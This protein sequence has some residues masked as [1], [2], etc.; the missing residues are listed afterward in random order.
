MMAW[1]RISGCNFVARPFRIGILVFAFLA[2]IAEPVAAGETPQANHDNAEDELERGI[3]LVSGGRYLESL[4]VFNQFKQSAPQDSRP[5]FYSAMALKE[6]GRL[7]AAALELQEAVRLAPGKPE[8]LVLQ[9]NVLA[10]LEQNSDAL[11]AL[12]T[13]EKQGRAQLE[14]AWLKMLAQTYLRL[15]KTDEALKVLALLSERSPKDADVDAARG[16]VYVAKGQFKLALEVLNKSIEKESANNPAAYFELGKILYQ[17]GQLGA[18]KLALLKAVAQDSQNAEYLF[19][20]GVVCLA[21]D[22]VD[23]AITHLQRAEGAASVFPGVYASLGRAYRQKG[24]RVR[25]E[26]YNNRFQQAT[27]AQR[28]K[29][30]KTRTVDRLLTQGEADLDNGNVAEAR[31]LFEQAA[32]TDPN[33][34]EPHGYLA[35]MLLDS[36]DLDRAYPH[37]A[38]ME[39]IESDSVVGNYLMAKY[40][41][42]RN[43]F[44]RAR[45]YGERVKL[46][47]P[48]NSELRGF[49]GSIYEKLGRPTD[50]TREYEVSVQLAPDRTDFQESLRRIRG[51]EAQGKPA[52]PEKIPKP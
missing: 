44:E 5:Y 14:A 45:D 17:D 27:A 28:D 24:N 2:A 12:A 38:K 43:E 33:R 19:Q 25:A 22:E 8:Y 18:A 3:S 36:G 13:V 21:G 48:A 50:A 37:L 47:R 49:L 31:S 51:Q 9:A 4:A 6:V 39:A 30:D 32:F 42:G 35:E 11:R 40:Y 16:K 20:L 7:S 29:N 52:T 1:L 34:W 46:S 41:F 10:Q 26:E 23:E 15:W